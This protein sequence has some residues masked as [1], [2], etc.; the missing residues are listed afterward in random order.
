MS[1]SQTLSI[2]IPSLNEATHLPLLIA[3]LNLWPHQLEICVCDANSSDQSVLIAKLSGAKVIQHSEP[4]R[5]AQLH[6][7]ASNTNGEWL[8]FLHADCRMPREWPKV[9]GK[10]I[11][12]VESRN[13]AWFFDFQVKGKGIEMKLLEIAVAI[14]S[15]LFRRPYGDQGLLIYRPLYE[16]IGGYKPIYLME[17]LDIIQRISKRVQIK[18]LGLPLYSDGRRWDNINFIAKAWDNA[19]LR[20]RWR[21]GE[22]SKALSREY[23]KNQEQKQY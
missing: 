13:I 8:L 14:R 11:S 9:L 4:N 22:Y 15:N 19:K 12:Q 3:D 10:V 21:K 2:V 18:S 17:D 23:Y 6:H 7:G 1:K 16:E 20:R 5:G